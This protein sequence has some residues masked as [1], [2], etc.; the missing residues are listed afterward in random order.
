MLTILNDDCIDK[1]L[2]WLSLDDLFSCSRTC[3]RLQ[4]LCENH[5]RRKFS[6]EVKIEIVNG[7][8][9]CKRYVKYFNNFVKN[10]TISMESSYCNNAEPSNLALINFVKTKCDQNLNKITIAGDWSLVPFCEQ[11]EN[12]LRNVEIVQFMTRTRSGHDEE[13]FLKYCPSITKLTLYDMAHGENVNSILQQTYHQLKHFH[14]MY[15]KPMNMNPETMKMFFQRN[16]KIQCVVWKFLDHKCDERQDE[17]KLQCIATVVD[18]ALYLEHLFLVIDP[19][20]ADWF[21]PIFSYLEVLCDRENFKS[22]EMEFDSEEAAKKVLGSHANQLASFKKFT[23]IRLSGVP[24]HKVIKELGSLVH[25]EM[26][27]W[28]YPDHF[29]EDFDSCLWMK[30]H[31]AEGFALPQIKELQIEGKIHEL[32]LLHFV[33][34]FVSQ[35]PNLKRIWWPQCNSFN[36]MSRITELCRARETLKDACELTIFSDYET[37]LDHKLVKFKF[38]EFETGFEQSMFSKCCMPSAQ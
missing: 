34:Q 30:N 29:Y 16:D 5:F 26:I 19:A 14:C 32:I 25:L 22:L 8:L 38:V 31:V 15:V 11:I 2:E 33:T 13:T 28:F 17:A 9:V 37:N 12:Y 36:L 18:Y 27:V 21:G 10:L 4:A 20:M 24:I 3:K 1:I 6:N 23:K 7:K 35:C